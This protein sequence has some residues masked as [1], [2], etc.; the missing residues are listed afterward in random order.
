MKAK[1]G[2]WMGLAIT[3]LLEAG[4]FIPIVKATEWMFT[5]VFVLW[6]ICLM[7]TVIFYGVDCAHERS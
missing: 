5:T 7:V 1:K 6:L 3:I 4:L 2:T